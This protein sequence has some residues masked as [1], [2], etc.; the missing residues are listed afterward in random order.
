MTAEKVFNYHMKRKGWSRPGYSYLVEESGRL[1]NV[2]EH[3]SKPEIKHSEYTF[4]VRNTTGL[5]R[6]ARHICYIGGLLDANTWAD[7]RT[8]EQKAVL[9]DF[10]RFQLRLNPKL[11]VLGHNKAQNKPCPGYDVKHDL[12]TRLGIP[13]WN[14]YHGRTELRL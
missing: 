12:R 11:I 2:W 8:K 3:S 6:N 4:G 10:V 5:N 7:T 14:L 1:V 13:D 9:D